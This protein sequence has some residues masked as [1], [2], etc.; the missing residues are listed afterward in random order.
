VT[1]ER[2]ESRSEREYAVERGLGLL[3]EEMQLEL[4]ILHSTQGTLIRGVTALYTKL[5]AVQE[6]ILMAVSQAVTDVLA[7]IDTATNDVAA[8]LKKLAG[9]IGT[10][11]T[12]AE[13]DT[14]VTQLQAK[15]DTL[16]GLAADPANP[17]P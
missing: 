10:G 15:A 1:T 8:E 17:V 12:Q 3:L 6:A 5:D 9:Q 11:M 2:H 13:V 14:L 16:E 4:K 7:K